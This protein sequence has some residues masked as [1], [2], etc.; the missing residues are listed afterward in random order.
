MNFTLQGEGPGMVVSQ[1]IK[2][3]ADLPPSFKEAIQQQ[4]HRA[5]SCA[6]ELQSFQQ[7]Y[8]KFKF[9]SV[10]CYQA[11][12]KYQKCEAGHLVVDQQNRKK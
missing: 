9:T 11:L 12:D 10:D 5:E 8:A 3:P 1:I 7:C 4:Q 2:N 6:N